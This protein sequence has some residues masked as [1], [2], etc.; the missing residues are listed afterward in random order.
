MRK[1]TS[2]LIFAFTAI[3]VFTLVSAP[4]LAD[5][6][7]HKCDVTV[8]YED[9]FF[10]LKES[11]ENIDKTPANVIASACDQACL[12]LSGNAQNKCTQKCTKSAKV[13]K[14][15]CPV[16]M[17]TSPLQDEVNAVLYDVKKGVR[18]SANLLYDDVVYDVSGTFAK[19][20]D[21]NEELLKRGCRQ[22]CSV[23]HKARVDTT[24]VN[25]CVD[26]CSSRGQV[27]SISCEDRDN[28]TV[29]KLVEPVQTCSGS[30]LFDGKSETYTFDL[31]LRWKSSEKAFTIQACDD[32]CD[33]YPNEHE[34]ACENYCNFAAK[35][36]NLKCESHDPRV[37]EKLSAANKELTCSANVLH[38][39]KSYPVTLDSIRQT[40]SDA[41]S[42]S[43]SAEFVKEVC[44]NLCDHFSDE[45][46]RSCELKCKKNA[47]ANDMKCTDKS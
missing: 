20:A 30:I 41:F 11:V 45:E 31:R 13:I 9:H 39:G 46:E 21:P 40:N 42:K 7:D 25:E 37:S 5:K 38:E 24:P 22:T 32:L 8:S 3:C 26:L 36:S 27:S 14:K 1:S 43:L 10:H 2:L 18:C 17:N 23:R 35:I 28:I 12:H 4:A 16:E 47:V 19:D 44:D 6:P 33:P 15:S 34:R 29:Q